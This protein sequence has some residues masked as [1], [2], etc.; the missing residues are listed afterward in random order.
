MVT[1]PPEQVHEVIGAHMLLDGYGFVLDLERS[2]GSRLVD[3]RDGS[4]YLDMFGFYAS[5]AVGFNHPALVGDA[6]YQADLAIAA[7]IKPGNSSTYTTYLATFLEVF[8][9]VVGDPSLPHVVLIDTG[10]LAVEN[11][12]KVAFDYKSRRNEAAGRPRSLGTRVL[13]LTKAFHGRSGYTLSLTNTDPVKTDRFPAFD[14]PRIPVPAVSRDLTDEQIDRA[15][16]EALA[17]A[18][19]AFA[20]YPHDIAAFIVEPIQGE[21]GDNHMRPS[22]LQAMEALCHE[23]DALFIVDEV[24]TG[25]GT[26]GTTWAY[27]A[28]GVAPDIVVFGKKMQVC[29]LMAGRRVEEVPDNALVVSS[30]LGSTWAG[31]LVDIVR[32]TRILELVEGDGLVQRAAESGAHLLLRL[33]ALERALPTLV[34]NARGR[35]LFC[36]VDLPDGTL[37]GEILERLAADERVLL[38]PSGERTIRFRPQLAVERS[39]LD[40]AVDALER[41]VATVGG[42]L[43]MART[44]GAE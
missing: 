22:F 4:V 14:W 38:L 17:S 34:S 33:E 19:A 18:R 30:R 9:R 1:V 32:A 8:S 16:E 42:R 44:G 41:V 5:N 3:Q 2:R 25:V 40:L 39:D 26:T 11:A 37:R 6:R 20:A 15:E 12:L 21:G 10:A 35:G 36:A 29:G 13:H 31:N 23:H 28:M 24:Q 27:Q 43:A 7:Q